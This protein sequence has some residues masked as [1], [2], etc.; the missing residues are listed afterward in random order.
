MIKKK[1]PNYSNPSL[2]ILMKIKKNM[3]D[4]YFQCLFPR[5]QNSD[6]DTFNYIHLMFHIPKSCKV[7]R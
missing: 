6:V 4:I 3:N 7:S 5:N 2:S 1:P